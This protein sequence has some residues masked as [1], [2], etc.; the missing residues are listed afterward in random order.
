[1]LARAAQAAPLAP[2]RKK[3]PSERDLRG[4]ASKHACAA[5]VGGSRIETIACQGQQ[6]L[7]ASAG[8]GSQGAR[9][10]RR[11]VFD[12]DT[13]PNNE[14]WLSSKLYIALQACT[15]VWQAS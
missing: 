7:S 15:L 6:I 13:M 11:H 5:Q 8:R 9:R 14:S 3:E 2:A 12:Q 1:M 4:G 10:A